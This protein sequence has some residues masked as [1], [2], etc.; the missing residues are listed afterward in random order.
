MIVGLTG[1]IGS[2]KTTVAKL[3]YKLGVP[4]YVSDI[5]AKQLMVTNIDLVAAIKDLLGD[6]AYKENQLNRSYI[7][8]KVFNN[9]A[10]LS[11]LNALVHPIVA[12]DFKQW[13]AVQE[14]PYVIKESAI[15]FETNG[16]KECDLIITVTAPLEERVNRVVKRD[17]VEEKQVKARID[18]QISDAE[19]IKHSQFVIYNITLSTTKKEIFKIHNRI[20]KLT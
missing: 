11:K 2:G 10:L 5:E 6:E 17:G 20:L 8:H 18:N 9:K 14:F 3:F 12:K 16:D 15:L 7:S 1:G 19:K 13:Y 4:I